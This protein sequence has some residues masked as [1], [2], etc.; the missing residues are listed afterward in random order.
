MDDV[1]RLRLENL[2]LMRVFK[3]GDEFIVAYLNP[4]TGEVGV[5][6][7][8]ELKTWRAAESCRYSW[9]GLDVDEEDLGGADDRVYPEWAER[10][11]H[12][13]APKTQ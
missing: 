2:D 6:P 11:C 10:H 9:A 13:V 3:Y 5:I 12:V 8:P 1:L 7:A 4:E